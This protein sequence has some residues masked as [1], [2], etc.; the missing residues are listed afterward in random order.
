MLAT[1]CKD[2]E[3]VNYI[4]ANKVQYNPEKPRGFFRVEQLQRLLTLTVVF[5]R[6]LEVILSKVI[7][8]TLKK[9]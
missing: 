1:I 2:K 9:L 3:G 6:I 5:G 4:T 7:S 8:K